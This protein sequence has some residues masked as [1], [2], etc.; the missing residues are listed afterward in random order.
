MELL[1]QMVFETDLQWKLTLFNRAVLTHA[2]YGEED[3]R[4]GL[5]FLDMVVPEER[6]RVAAYF[7]RRL[8]N[9]FVAGAEYNL[10]RKD[11]TIFPVMI[12]ASPLITNDE[13]RGLQGVI[14]DLYDRKRLEQQLIQA[15]KLEATGTLA[16]GIAHD[17][18]NLLMGIQGYASLMLLDMEPSHPHYDRL[19]RIEDYVKSGA[20]LTKHLLGF[21]QGGRYEVCPTQMNDIIEKSSSLFGRTKKEI[22]MHTSLADDLWTVEVDRGQME[23]VLMNLYMNAWQAMP[24]GGEIFLESSNTVLNDDDTHLYEIQPGKYIKITVTDTGVG[25]DVKT[26]ERIFEPFF[27]T[28]TMGRG[29]GLGLAM[30]Y[31]IIKG[32]G[33][34]IH[35]YSE[36]GHGTTFNIY[37]PASH[38]DA[39]VEKQEAYQ[40]MRGTETILL[41]DDERTVLEVSSEILASM[42]YKVFVA[43]SGKDAL[44]LYLDHIDSIQLVI[45]DL[46]MPGMSGGEAFDRFK[47]MNS[48]VNV[49][50]S[51]GYGMNQNIQQILDRGCRGFIQKPFNMGDLSKKLREV[52]NA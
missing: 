31:G 27:T 37:L 15:Q 18:N 48:E 17:F 35:V 24:S 20:N 44:A 25:M 1:P 42:G 38:R 36:P 23:Q 34:M 40:I 49:L 2:G 50:L 6:E 51:S 26:R 22:A 4:Q 16:G 13:V 10:R 47:Q 3:I 14:F 45:L 32:H 9:E 7:K 43:N 41:V 5:T 30:V 8:Q 39:V 28:K 46:I 33:G 52:L 12:Y 11:G 29:T 19:K 21:A